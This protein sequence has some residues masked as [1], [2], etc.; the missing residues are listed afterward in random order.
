MQVDDKILSGDGLEN[1]QTL[2]LALAASQRIWLEGTADLSYV[3]Q[4]VEAGGLENPG[5]RLVT[6]VETL[7]LEREENQWLKAA[8]G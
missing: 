3:M 2:E 6:S 7:E 1:G 4:Q 5:Q 8:E